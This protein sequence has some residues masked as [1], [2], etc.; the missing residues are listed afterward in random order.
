MDPS[1]STPSTSMDSELS[2]VQVG[3]KVRPE[4]YT[5][6]LAKSHAKP[7]ADEPA[8]SKSMSTIDRLV[9]NGILPNS[10]QRRDQFGAKMDAKDSF[11]IKTLTR[12]LEREITIRH[13]T[14]INDGPS[15]MRVRRFD[16]TSQSMRMITA[17]ATLATHQFQ[18]TQMLPYMRKSLALSYKKVEI[19]RAINASIQTMHRSSLEKLEAIK[20]NTAMRDAGKGGIFK[21]LKD[22]VT[23]RALFRVGDNIAAA[24]LDRYDQMYVKHISPRLARLEQLFNRDG[25]KGTVNGV[26]RTLRGTL[27][28]QRGKL[29]N[30]SNSTGDTHGKWTKRAAGLGARFLDTAVK[31]GQKTKLPGFVNTI[32]TE[33][34]RDHTSVWG[35]LRPLQT[36]FDQNKDDDDLHSSNKVVDILQRT[37]VDN[38]RYFAKSLTHLANLDRMVS[39]IRNMGKSGI[40]PSSDMTPDFDLGGDKGRPSASPSQPAQFGPPKP[41]MSVRARRRYEKAKKD[42][43]QRQRGTGGA[44]NIRNRIHSVNETLRDRLESMRALREERKAQGN[45]KKEESAEEIAAREHARELAAEK[46]KA[47]RERELEKKRIRDERRAAAAER[48]AKGKARNDHIQTSKVSEA[49]KN[50]F[51]NGF[52]ETGLNAK[53]PPKAPRKTI[54]Q[55]IGGWAASKFEGPGDDYGLLGKAW[56]LSSN[57][58]INRKIGKGTRSL[59]RGI[60]KGTKLVGK[61]LVKSP[62]T[63]A[64]GAWSATKVAGKVAVGATKT[65]WGIGKTIAKLG[66]GGVGIGLVG[67]GVN[68]LS[69]K[70]LTGGAKRAG[71]T[72]GTAMEYG[73]IGF[74]LG[75]PVGAAIGASAGVLIENFDV[76]SHYAKK[77]GI[78]FAAIGRGISNAASYVWEGT[79]GVVKGMWTGLVGQDA[80]YDWT[81]RVKKQEKP[82]IVGRTIGFFF[83]RD[84]KKDRFGNIVDAGQTSVFGH[85]K[86]GFTKTF[87]GDKD[88]DG[89]FK[90]G[91]SIISMIKDKAGSILD[92]FSQALTGIG[93][94]I[95]NSSVGKAVQTAYNTTAGAVQQTAGDIVQGVQ[96]AVGAFTGLKPGQKATRADRNNN[97]GNVIANKWTATLPGYVGSDGRFAIFASPEHGFAAQIKVIEGYIRKGT[98]T[99]RKIIYKYAPPHENDT[100]AYVNNVCKSLGVNPDEPLPVEK[101]PAMAAAMAKIEG[102]HGGVGSKPSPVPAAGTGTTATPAKPGAP[103]AATP[104]KPGST[105][106]APK[107]TGI[108]AV[109]ATKGVSSVMGSATP[110]STGPTTVTP[111]AFAALKDKQKA[112]AANSNNKPTTAPAQ[113]PAA[114]PAVPTPKPAT[115]DNRPSVASTSKRGDVTNA[116]VPIPVH[117]G[118]EEPSYGSGNTQQKSAKPAASNAAV[119]PV[120]YEIPSSVSPKSGAGDIGTLVRALFDNTAALERNTSALTGEPTTKSKTMVPSNMQPSRVAMKSAT[121]VVKTSS[122]ISPSVVNKTIPTVATPAPT[123]TPTPTTQIAA[124]TPAPAS[125]VI[126]KPV[127]PAAT[128]VSAPAPTPAPI[129]PSGPQMAFAPPVPSASSGNFPSLKR[130]GSRSGMA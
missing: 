48:T 4:K 81:G 93:N 112:G 17:N 47:R 74:M 42:F 58:G 38:E 72:L 65:A 108:A 110:S 40:G 120:A 115:N 95:A 9:Q 107:P 10:R 82:S 118:S 12:K 14:E 78:D 113:T 129:A 11:K 88:K 27:N 60:W 21:R 92:T 19:L 50:R 114:K 2:Q 123:T 36:K 89:T 32:A 37:R 13:K 54:K 5:G 119:V 122:V 106:T 49:T 35:S 91:T 116:V 22:S 3:P 86:N 34:V 68:Y 28:R 53:K 117:Y 121:P 46:A 63:I 125:S 128:P 62:A 66:K 43:E 44:A 94:S 126:S 55:R 97:P 41:G 85:I 52:T 51:R 127:T 100:G 90:P 76:V 59:G 70:Y 61:G 31:V 1:D 6:G 57:L 73:S 79:K 39:D 18:K 111:A 98:N 24:Y 77:I 26:G 67:A 105:P 84:A 25:A 64:K 75:G 20:M 103:T 130:A 87:F 80:E 8:R 23:D 104:G 83:G 99:P 16:I 29:R 101:V 30:V 102:W 69:D 15:H 71:K 56:N 109:V 45:T 33:S 7:H 96:G 124:A